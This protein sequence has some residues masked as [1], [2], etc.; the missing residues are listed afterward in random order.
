MGLTTLFNH[1]PSHFVSNSS[2]LIFCQILEVP[3][4]PEPAD[5]L[6]FDGWGRTW[7]C[8]FERDNSYLKL[9]RNEIHYEYVQ[10]YILNWKFRNDK[11]GYLNPIRK[12]LWPTNWKI[13]P[14]NMA[15]SN[16]AHYWRGQTVISSSVIFHPWIILNYHRTTWW[17]LTKCHFSEVISPSDLASVKWFGAKWKLIIYG[18]VDTVKP[19]SNWGMIL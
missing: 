19:E 4:G 11:I 12:N 9:I 18:R 15:P 14:S 13:W 8:V 5:W 1:D 3:N 7:V 10:L 17:H 6:G 2:S 16:W